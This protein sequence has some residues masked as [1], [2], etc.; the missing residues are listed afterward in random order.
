LS[1]PKACFRRQLLKSLHCSVHGT[2]ETLAIT[3]QDP[4]PPG[5]DCAPA[6]QYWLAVGTVTLHPQQTPPPNATSGS[7]PLIYVF[8]QKT[9]FVG[10]FLSTLIAVLFSL[11]WLIIDSKIR[12]LEPFHQ[13]SKDRGA[14]A[15]KSLGMDYLYPF[16]IVAPIKALFA[17]HWAPLLT[18]LL[19]ICTLLITP[20]APEFV[21]VRMQ[22]SCDSQTE[23]CVPSLSI[24]PAAGRAIEGLLC[25]MAILTILLLIYLSR[26]STGVFAEPSS[27]AGLATLFHNLEVMEDF[28]NA[29]GAVSRN[30][31]FDSL[32][33]RR[34]KVDFYTDRDRI[35]K[36]GLVPLAPS[37]SMPANIQAEQPG[38]YQVPRGSS[39]ERNISLNR[40]HWKGALGLIALLSGLVTTIIYYKL[41]DNPGGFERFMDSQG[42]GVRFLFTS[43]GVIIKLYWSSIFRGMVNL[44]KL[45][46][47]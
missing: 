14:E 34:Y 13:L 11:P 8:A 25:F 47:D 33:K 24:F 41:T 21:S 44:A 39:S 6:P 16:A 27:I 43:I 5:D 22:G 35:Q 15:R 10:A 45:S 29:L 9:Y 30:Q 32:R 40:P 12:A 17:G 23:G 42:F 37:M 38:D 19:S 4:C 2:L 28:R 31:S 26:Y 46:S 3:Y 20:V 7:P 18:S 36:Y 1:L